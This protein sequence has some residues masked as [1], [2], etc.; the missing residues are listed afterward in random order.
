[1]IVMVGNYGPVYKF[2][3]NLKFVGLSSRIQC[4]DPSPVEKKQSIT[5]QPEKIWNIKVIYQ[6]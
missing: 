2:T 1:M 5:K 6:S 3:F 4:C